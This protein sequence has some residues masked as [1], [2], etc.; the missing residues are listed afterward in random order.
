LLQDLLLSQ[1]ILQQ[2]AGVIIISTHLSQAQWAVFNCLL[3]LG[4]VLRC[5]KDKKHK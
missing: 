2:V 3:Q 5:R 1:I 4:I